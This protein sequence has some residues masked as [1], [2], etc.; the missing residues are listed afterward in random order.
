MCICV[1]VFLSLL[2]QPFSPLAFF[3]FWAL[4]GVGLACFP[5][6]I[7]LL[8]QMY[9]HNVAQAS[10]AVL[11]PLTIDGV[12]SPPIFSRIFDARARGVDAMPPFALASACS[13]VG[14]ALW[15][16][17]MA[18]LPWGAPT[19][20]M[21]FATAAKSHAEAAPPRRSVQSV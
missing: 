15:L 14:I 1:P 18:Q 11:V 4:P 19:A 10:S 2:L 20:A 13:L 7:G 3:F 12:L 9:P 8:I 6:Y 17:G 21:D 5:F 16:H